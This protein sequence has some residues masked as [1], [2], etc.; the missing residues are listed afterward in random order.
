ML[1]YDECRVNVISQFHENGKPKGW[2]NYTFVIESD[3]MLYFGESVV[4]CVKKVLADLSSED[5]RVEYVSHEVEF[6]EPTD[7]SARVADAWDAITINQ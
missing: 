4:D 3:L 2:I 1:N 5:S 6:F 7:I